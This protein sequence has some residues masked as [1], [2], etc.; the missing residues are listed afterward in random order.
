M[1]S[2]EPRRDLSVRLSALHEWGA[3]TL[4]TDL[5]SAHLYVFDRETVFEVLQAKEA[6]HSIQQV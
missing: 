6:I 3:I 1:T 4:R 5:S 2:K